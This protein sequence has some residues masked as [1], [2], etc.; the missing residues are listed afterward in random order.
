MTEEEKDTRVNYMMAKFD[1]RIKNLE[2]VLDVIRDLIN[3][4]EYKNLD[5][6]NEFHEKI[7]NI[8][9]KLDWNNGFMEDKLKEDEDCRKIDWKSTIKTSKTQENAKQNKRKCDAKSEM[10]LI[11]R[12]MESIYNSM[13][14]YHDN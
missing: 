6:I 2:F 1:E 4:I 8:M 13:F 11:R 10:D 5:K 7:N 12:V 9:S 3:R 14:D